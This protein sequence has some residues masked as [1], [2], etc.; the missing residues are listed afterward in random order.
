MEMIVTLQA[1]L[2]SRNQNEV[3]Q[4]VLVATYRKLLGHFPERVIRYLEKAA[5]VRCKW[6]PTV[7]ECLDLIAEVDTTDP[8]LRKQ[9]AVRSLVDRENAARFDDAMA[10]LASGEVDQAWIDGLPDQWKQIAEVRMLL[11]VHPDGS[12]T[13]RRSALA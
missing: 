1:V 7:K 10:A 8:L 13:L 2:P 9:S 5:V 3:A 12:Y 4:A 6:F 11:W